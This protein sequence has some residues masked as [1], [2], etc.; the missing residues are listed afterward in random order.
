MHHVDAGGPLLGCVSSRSMARIERRK[1]RKQLG[2]IGR[3]CDKCSTKQGNGLNRALGLIEA[4]RRPVLSPIQ[5]RF[6]PAQLRSDQ[7]SCIKYPKWKGRNTPPKDASRFPHILGDCPTLSIHAESYLGDENRPRLQRPGSLSNRHTSKYEALA[8]VF[9]AI[10]APALRTRWSNPHR[11]SHTNKLPLTRCHRL[12]IVFNSCTPSIAHDITQYTVQKGNS[13]HTIEPE[14][15]PI[16]TKPILFR[17][18]TITYHAC[19]TLEP[20]T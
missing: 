14:A 9:V 18:V 20:S 10:L 7:S 3:T 19:T 17:K 8:D 4:V 5:L 1:V 16:R 6:V 11:R 13:G 12:S 2:S 15:P